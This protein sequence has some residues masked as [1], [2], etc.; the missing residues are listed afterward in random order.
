MAASYFVLNGFQVWTPQIQQ[1]KV[2]LLLTRGREVVKVQV[3]TAYWIERGDNRYLSCNIHGDTRS[4][5]YTKDEFDI[6][7]VVGPD[8]TRLWEIPWRKVFGKIRTLTLDR[9][10][11]TAGTRR[12]KVDPSKWERL[13]LDNRRRK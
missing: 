8:G 2:D 13:L 1:S 7:A 4:T 12:L 5:D 11:P 3:K 6:L 9:V 10:G